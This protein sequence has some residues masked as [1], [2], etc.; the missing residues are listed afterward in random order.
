MFKRQHVAGMNDVLKRFVALV[1]RRKQASEFVLIRGYT[2]KK[3]NT[4][5]ATPIL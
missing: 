2:I 1:F 4:V 5:I 3:L